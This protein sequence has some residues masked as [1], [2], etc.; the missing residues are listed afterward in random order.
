VSPLP[1][2]Q[3]N[4]DGLRDLLSVVNSSRG[5]DEILAYLVRKAHDVL[6]SDGAAVYLIDADDPTLLRAQASYGIASCLLADTT[7]VGYPVTGLAVSLRR[8]VVVSN[9]AAAL[10]REHAPSVEKQ[11]EDRCEFVEV[12]RPGPVTVDDVEQRYRNDSIATSFTT[13]IA[14]PLVAHDETFGALELFYRDQL[15]LDPR[16]IDISLAFAQQGALALENAR[17]RTQAEQRLAEIGRRQRVAEALRDLLAVV[18]SNHDLNQILVELLE[19]SSRLLGNEAGAIYLKEH[20]EDT[21][22]RVKAS[23]GL[24]REQIAERVRIGSPTTGLAVKQV[25]TLVCSDLS[26]ALGDES[27]SAADTQLED[28]GSYARIVRLGPRTDP[29]LETDSPQ[30]PRVQ[31]LVNTFRS[32]VSTP[33][34][35][36][37]RTLGAITLFH[38]SPHHFER[39]EVQLVQAF[40]QQASLAIENAHLHTEA[41]QR[42][43]ELEAL[44]RADEVLHGSLRLNEVLRSLVDVAAEVLQADRTTVRLWDTERNEY[45]VAATHGENAVASAEE[46][47]RVPI[48]VSG[49][50]FGLFDVCFGRS[51]HVTRREQRVVHALAQR[52]GLA[53]HNARLFEQAQHV[54]TIEER[55]RLARELHDA[56]TQTLFSASLIAEVVPRLWDRDPDEGRQRVDDLRRL[57]RGAL[58]EMRT[59]LL[60]LRPAALVETPLVQ[61]FSQLAETTMSRS[62][63]DV[64]VHA[65]GEPVALAPDV[66]VALYRVV[67][68]ALNNIVKH[69]AASLASIHLCWRQRGVD[70]RVKDDGRG[71][72]RSDISPGRLGL[73]IMDERARAIGA[74]L[75]VRSRPT[76]G[77]SVDAHWRK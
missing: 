60:E 38:S 68:E 22:L 10:A 14:V 17:L 30:Q 18:N 59:L 16:H 72:V 35:T 43:H 31:R 20:D 1:A 46:E 9:L 8:P 41:E 67:Q 37:G 45:V 57:T 19:Q 23:M 49:R 39:E 28:F 13:L 27:L 24:R 32:V 7:P 73:G 55:E 66:H 69:A 76:V 5:I 33:L 36:R 3:L 56:V 40:A 52:A 50:T 71:F 64:T 4:L 65:H 51:H 54:A 77:T 63:V 26:K 62:S 53:I 70:V 42:L 34:V 44:Y 47:L 74:T 6:E 25:R 61:L 2:R 12:I 11:F 75:R 29:D 15:A 58:S 21:T 48:T